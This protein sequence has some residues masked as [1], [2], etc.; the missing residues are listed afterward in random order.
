MDEI[1]LSSNTELAYMEGGKYSSGE[2]DPEEL[3]LRK[4][5]KEAIWGG[6]SQEQKWGKITL[7]YFKE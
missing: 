7:N 4:V 3:G 1:S 2:I 5:S 6:D